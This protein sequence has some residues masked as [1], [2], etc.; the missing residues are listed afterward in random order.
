M[1]KTDL[2]AKTQN[3]GPGR[4]LAWAL[5]T[6][7][8]VLAVGGL[9]LAFSGDGEVVDQS[10][11]PTPTTVPTTATTPSTV[12]TPTLDPTRLTQEEFESIEPGAYFVDADGDPT[13]TAGA[14]FVIENQGWIG[15]KEGVNFNSEI[16]AFPH[17]LH[18]KPFVEPFTPVCGQSGSIAGNPLA[19]GSTAADLADGFAASGF[20]V[21]EAPAP[22]S[23]FGRDGYHVVVEVPE[24]CLFGGEGTPHIWIYPGDVMEVWSFDMDGSVVMVEALWLTLSPSITPDDERLAPL[25]DVIDSLVLTP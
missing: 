17:T 7:A 1:T 25:R 8:I 13:T 12:L 9:Y 23:A 10:T 11:V 4:G 5:A 20:T 19:A 24:G 18:L 2:P 22:V 16:G 3:P 21:L 15:S 6:F 14:T